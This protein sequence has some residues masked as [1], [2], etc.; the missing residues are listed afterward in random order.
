MEKYKARLAASARTALGV[1][2]PP[3]QESPSDTVF[4]QGEEGQER[5]EAVSREV[6]RALAE[7]ALT[8][9]ADP[10]LYL[11]HPENEV[12]S[13]YLEAQGIDVSVP[14]AIVDYRSRIRSLT[15]KGAI[16][17]REGSIAE[18][19][20]DLLHKRLSW[21][22]QCLSKPSFLAKS[23]TSMEAELRSLKNQRKKRK[24]LSREGGSPEDK[25]GDELDLECLRLE[26]D[27][28]MLKEAQKGNKGRLSTAIAQT[29]RK[30]E[31]ERRREERMVLIREAEEQMKVKIEEGN[32]EELKRTRRLAEIMRDL[33]Q[34]EPTYRQ[35]M[36]ELRKDNLFPP[37]FTIPGFREIC[38]PLFGLTQPA[39]YTRPKGIDYKDV[40][41]TLK[42]NPEA[43]L[44]LM[45][46]G[47]T[48]GA[49]DIIRYS[50]GDILFADCSAESPLGRRN[51]VYDEEA[52]SHK[53]TEPGYFG[54]AVDMARK[55]KVDLMSPG[56]YARLL[57]QTP[58]QRIEEIGGRGMDL[59]LPDGLEPPEHGVGEFDR[60]S[61]SRLKT[62]ENIRKAGRAVYGHR[63]V[64]GRG[65]DLGVFLFQSGAHMHYP[66]GG[67]RAS[68][69]A[70]S[71]A[72]T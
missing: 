11:Y 29:H 3:L 65:S 50:K 4:F 41:E 44:S 69:R 40:I 45:K 56:I 15:S 46:M 39:H 68:L 1:V 64:D 9:L 14:Q 59:S 30:I 47:L 5:A 17:S 8:V 57:Q 28:R 18:A 13:D 34:L 43:L 49:P 70:F 42:A 24:M 32:D 31:E 66:L 21:L 7:H 52:E 12:I 37:D 48:G 55:M 63:A 23:I 26:E 19:D 2:L 6:E 35:A 51:C 33:P 20:P 36:A 54:N 61:W 38:E 58:S 72:S 10:L 22:E 67:W 53:E 71:R 16:G 27:L 25:K 60:E 62:N